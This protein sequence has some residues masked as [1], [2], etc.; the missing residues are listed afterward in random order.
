MIT[1][2]AVES[3]WGIDILHITKSDG[4][5]RIRWKEGDRRE[6]VS[7]KW[8]R[9]CNLAGGD[10]KKKKQKKWKRSVNWLLICTLTNSPSILPS[11][12]S[13]RTSWLG[14]MVDG[15]GKAGDSSE[16]QCGCDGRWRR[17]FVVI[18]W[19]GVVP[20]RLI[21][22]T[23]SQSYIDAQYSSINHETMILLFEP[24]KIY[25]NYQ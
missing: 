4:E 9:K 10:K 2:D 14:R 6:R 12:S 23:T 7:R 13:S 11:P 20:V 1:P 21:K 3:L 25:Q 18:W 24:H 15:N 5:G 22:A 17:G 16:F 19:R 8:A